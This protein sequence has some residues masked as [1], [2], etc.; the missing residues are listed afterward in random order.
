MTPAG[1]AVA[2][3]V[4]AAHREHW[5]VLLAT[6]VR[7]LRDLD[8]AE[9]CVQDAFAAAVRTWRSDGVPGNPAAWLTTATRHRALDRLRRSA[10]ERRALPGLIAETERVT[11]DGPGRAPRD[12]ARDDG[13]DLLRLV[14]LCAHPALAA[15]SRVALTLRAVCGVPTAAVARAMLVSEPTLAARLTRAKKKI[16]AAGIPL[17]LPAAAD[18]ARRVAGALD[19]VHLVLTCAHDDPAADDGLAARA[20]LLARALVRV[21]PGETEAR[22]LLAL[23]L[24]TGARAPARRDDAGA[25]VLL[26]E[27]DR[28]RWDAAAVAEGLAL[29]RGLLPHPAGR[30][31]LQAAIAAEHARAATAADTDWRQVLRLYDALLAEWPTPVVAL[32]RAVALAEVDGP[33]A[34]LQ[35][36]RAVADDPVLARYPWLPA[37]RAELH[38]RSGR[39]LAAADEYRAALALPVSPADAAFLRARLAAVTGGG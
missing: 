21:A 31:T 17:R 3:A 22:G 11:R 32:N 26:A 33:S 38:R 29:V 27:Q 24:L 34:A 35:A 25:V 14:L 18:R 5:P 15:E 10:T 1:D 13:E 6:T 16:A 23:A 19:V 12:D 9:D 4:E 7:L 37:T 2:T 30:F 28:S 8:A 39:P 20:V 36:L